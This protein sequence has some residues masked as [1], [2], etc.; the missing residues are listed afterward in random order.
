MFYYRTEAV[1][2]FTE[3]TELKTDSEVGAKRR[4]SREYADSCCHIWLGVK[5]KATGVIKPIAKKHSL[6]SAWLNL[7]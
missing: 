5:S 6:Q 1:G 2:K 3:W 4:L 7:Q